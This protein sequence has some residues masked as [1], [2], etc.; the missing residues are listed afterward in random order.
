MDKK[1]MITIEYL[2]NQMKLTFIYHHIFVFYLISN[3]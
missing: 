3:L 2:L 1:G